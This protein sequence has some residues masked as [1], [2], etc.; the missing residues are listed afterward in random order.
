MGAAPSD[1]QSYPA[2]RTSYVVPAG[3]PL[4]PFESN[5]SVKGWIAAHLLQ[6]FVKQKPIP[7]TFS[8]KC[9]ILTVPRNLLC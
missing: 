8:R 7:L 6:F 1:L 2:A 9:G 3:S 5:D 4:P